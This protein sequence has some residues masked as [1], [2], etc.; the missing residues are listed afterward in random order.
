[1]NRLG[2]RLLGR[3]DDL[4]DR[5]IALRRCRWAEQESLIGLAYVRRL[6]VE[7]GVHPD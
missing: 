3:F 1:M 6:A 7:L 5:Q 2:A 4:L